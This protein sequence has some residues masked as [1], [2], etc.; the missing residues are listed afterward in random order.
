MTEAVVLYSDHCAACHGNDGDGRGMAS[1][2]L[3]PRPRDFRK[4]FYRI[5]SSSNGVPTPADVQR[6]IRAGIPGTAM[7]SFAHLRDDQLEALAA[8]VL[9]FTKHAVRERLVA[10]KTKPEKLEALVVAR[11]TPEQPVRV[12]AEPV[13]SAAAMARA[14]RIF[15]ETCA[16][17]H[18]AD[19]SGRQDP[20]WRTEEGFPIAS[21]NF[22]AGAFKGG[23]SGADLYTRI[24]T[25]M[26]GTPMPSFSALPEED[27]WALVHYV[28]SLGKSAAASPS[29]ATAISE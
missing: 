7:P 16:T 26:P 13:S 22:T 25:G 9:S 8:Y 18:G 3:D 29:S 28:Q 19:G 20:A 17:C 6:T 4:G 5:V 2:M 1:S 14:K 12:P 15:A 24:Y 27:V 11:T 10:R 21:R 23:A